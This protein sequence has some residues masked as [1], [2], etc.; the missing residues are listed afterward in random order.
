MSVNAN[1]PITFLTAGIPDDYCFTTPQ[2]FNLDIVAALYGYIPGQYSVIIDSE[3]EPAVADRGKLWFKREVGGSP[4]GLLFAYFGG[5]W[6]SPNREP[7]SSAARRIFRG[8]AADVWSYDGGD[9]TDPSTNP[10]SAAAGAMWEIDTDFAARSPIGPG[11]LPLSGTVI[12]VGD[13]GGVDQ[14]TLTE[15]QT[16]EHTHKM[17]KNVSSST[18]LQ[19]DQKA[20]AWNGLFSGN[21]AY[22]LTEGDTP[23][24]IGKSGPSGSGQA[25]TNMSPYISTYFIRRTSRQFYLA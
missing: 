15:A 16:P 2:K 11:T 17:A 3:T 4:T 13:T 20:I 1:A 8:S 24:D 19:T 18:S 25:H 23:A 9:G 12:A 21:N 14:V 5:N 7:A 6:V 22:V 10:P